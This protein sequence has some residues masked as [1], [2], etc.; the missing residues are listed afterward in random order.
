MAKPKIVIEVQPGRGSAWW[1]ALSTEQKR[2][3]V[4]PRL[5]AK[6][7]NK[8]IG[9]TLGITPNSIA[10]LR[11][12]WNKGGHKNPYE[13]VFQQSEESTSPRAIDTSDAPDPPIPEAVI[14]EP[15]PEPVEII[16]AVGIDNFLPVAEPEQS[17]QDVPLGPGCEWTLS[18]SRGVKAQECGKSVVPGFRCCADHAPLVYGKRY[19]ARQT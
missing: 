14:E 10:S 4:F 3:L 5:I 18:S 9:E 12:R 8:A 6:E 1:T 17:E 2:A 13:L 15:E 7:S 16:Q 19:L 11:D